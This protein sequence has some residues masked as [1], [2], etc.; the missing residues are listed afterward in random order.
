LSQSPINN[1]ERAVA[2]ELGLILISFARLDMNLGLACASKCGGAEFER[3]CETLDEGF[4][5]RLRVFAAAVAERHPGGPGRKAYEDWIAD[6]HVVRNQRNR[7]VH[8]R[9]GFNHDGT[10]SSITGFP[11]S[12]RQVEQRFTIEQLTAVRVAM[13]DLNSRLAKLTKSW[14][15]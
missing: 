1:I 4:C 5:D 6:A 12:I 9:W 13:E 3:L 14:P 11:T 8:S 10:T 7:I 15:I 2:T